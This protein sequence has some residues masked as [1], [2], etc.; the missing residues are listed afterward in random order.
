MENYNGEKISTFDLV[1]QFLQEKK[2]DFSGL[3]THRY[4]LEDYRQALTDVSHKATAKTIK[5]VFEFD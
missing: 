1:I 4:R 5:A 3:I 2:L